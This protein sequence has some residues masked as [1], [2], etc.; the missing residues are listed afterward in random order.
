M[1]RTTPWPGSAGEHQLQDRYGTTERAQRF[2]SQ[3]VL[4]HLNEPMREFVVA[5]EMMFVATSDAHGE[6]DNTFRAGPTGFVRVLDD[7]RL[8][9]PEYRG[10]GVMASLG[11]ISENPHVGLLFMDFTQSV[12]GLHVNGRAT[13][14]EDAAMRAEY[15]DLDADDIPGRRPERWV[16]VEVEEAYIHCAKHIPRLVKAPRER[17]W[18]T[19][20]VRRKGGDFFQASGEQRPWAPDAAAEAASTAPDAAPEAASAASGVAPA[21]RRPAEPDPSEGPAEPDLSEAP[22]GVEAIGAAT[23]TGAA[24][25]TGSAAASDEARAPGATEA[26]AATVPTLTEPGRRSP[27]R[28]RRLRGLLGHRPRSGEDR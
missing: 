13:I 8:T 15:E 4:D 12:I 11:N 20:D 27:G 26:T 24:A 28:H 23:A 10:N 17:A 7:Q 19:D 21:A 16:V 5:Q 22:D 2:Y 25:A 1:D 6:C 18:G 3:Q 9:W 14:I